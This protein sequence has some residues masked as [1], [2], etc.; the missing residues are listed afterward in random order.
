VT[1]G[2]VDALEAAVRRLLDDRRYAAEL[3]AA[4]MVRFEAFLSIAA[5]AE[6]FER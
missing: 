4:G 6:R 1:P 2:D 5:F 3:A